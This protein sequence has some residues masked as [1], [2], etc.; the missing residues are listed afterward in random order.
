[1]ALISHL[2]TMPWHV[3]VSLIVVGA[4]A[5]IF[6]IGWLGAVLIPPLAGWGNGIP[7]ILNAN[8][9]D[10]PALFVRWDSGYYLTIA[11]QGYTSD[12]AERAF[13]PL[14]PFAVYGVHKVS[15]LSILL[16]GLLI[17]LICFWGVSLILYKWIR[18]DYEHP[19]ALLAVC[20]MYVF[21]VAFYGVAFYAESILLFTTIG[22]L[23]FARRGR[24]V[25]SSLMI[26]VAGLTRPTAFLLG[27]PYVLE[28]FQQR[29]FER[30]DWARFLAGMLIAPSGMLSYVIYLGQLRNE[31]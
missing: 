13:F 16:S 26:A 5:Y 20:L 18:L 11:E 27:V 31:N 21:P 3:Q 14:Y 29:H 24:F 6:S 28:F 10:L 2:W 25:R 7:V 4:V 12:G 19:Q 9:I 23:Y 30:N 1:M 17:S 8:P 15:G 22:S